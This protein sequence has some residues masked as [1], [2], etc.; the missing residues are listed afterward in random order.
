MT[1][2]VANAVVADTAFGAI[3]TAQPIDL[4]RW[5]LENPQISDDVLDFFAVEK[6]LAADQHI[7]NIG[8]TQLFLGVARLAVGAVED[9]KLAVAPPASVSFDLN[10]L[11][12]LSALILAVCAEQIG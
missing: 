10:L 2:D 6:L 8:I 5:I 4:V 3:E 1:D 12:H 9:G 11:H 7:G